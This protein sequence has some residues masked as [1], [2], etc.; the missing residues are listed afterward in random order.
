MLDH[1]IEVGQTVLFNVGDTPEHWPY[2]SPGDHRVVIAAKLS[3]EQD[4]Y[5][6]Y[7]DIWDGWNSNN[8]DIVIAGT[9]I[10]CM[11]KEVG[12]ELEI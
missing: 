3:P 6:F 2:I 4:V 7:Q 8:S 5:L 9:A 10:A 12:N 1:E 11:F